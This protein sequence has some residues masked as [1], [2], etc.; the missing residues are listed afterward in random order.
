MHHQITICL[1]GVVE[2][3]TFIWVRKRSQILDF[4]SMCLKIRDKRREDFIIPVRTTDAAGLV[5]ADMML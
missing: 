5:W 2:I 3:V 4:A 1:I